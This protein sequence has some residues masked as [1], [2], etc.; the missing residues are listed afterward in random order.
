MLDCWLISFITNF[1]SQKNASSF[2]WLLGKL[3]RVCWISL[4]HSALH[5]SFSYSRKS[6]GCLL[7]T[8]RVLINCNVTAAVCLGVFCFVPGVNEQ[9][10]DSVDLAGLYESVNKADHGEWGWIEQWRND[11]ETLPRWRV[12]AGLDSAL[13]KAAK[14]IW[15]WEICH[16]DNVGATGK[17]LLFVPPV[18]ILCVKERSTISWDEQRDLKNL[19]C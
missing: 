2:F 14:G 11:T 12:E 18:Q 9:S 5:V 3:L 10:S 15:L 16:N 7:L 6:S 4:S 8:L 1:P 19:A 17:I 13:V